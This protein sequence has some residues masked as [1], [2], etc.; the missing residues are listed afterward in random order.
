MWVAVI[1]WV[2]LLFLSPLS[3]IAIPVFSSVEL[4]S[5]FLN[6]SILISNLC[7]WLEIHSALGLMRGWQF[8]YLSGVFS[9]S[10]GHATSCKSYSI[11]SSCLFCVL[12]FV[13]LLSY[14]LNLNL[15]PFMLLSSELQVKCS[16]FCQNRRWLTHTW[17]IK[18][19]RCQ[20]SRSEKT[21]KP[22]EAEEICLNKH[23]GKVW[24][25]ITI[26]SLLLT[27]C[28]GYPRES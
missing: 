9:N 21:E 19:W 15:Q 6:W 2:N 22:A 13:Y 20:R 7:S 10:A 5:L 4:L 23:A 18:L 27:S 17:M 3:Q 26:K 14:S 8:F 25:L 28:G 16:D 24:R 11:F 1:R 12:F